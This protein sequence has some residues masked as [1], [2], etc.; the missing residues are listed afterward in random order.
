MSKKKAPEVDIYYQRRAKELV[1]L[2]FNKRFLND[3]LSRDSINWLED[4]LAF[5]ESSSCEMAAKTALLTAKLRD[6]A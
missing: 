3:E 2:L 1:D 5:V 6:K 4:Y